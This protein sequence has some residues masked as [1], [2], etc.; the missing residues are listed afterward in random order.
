MPGARALAANRGREHHSLGA[1]AQQG[2]PQAKAQ[3]H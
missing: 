2:P 1:E 3:S